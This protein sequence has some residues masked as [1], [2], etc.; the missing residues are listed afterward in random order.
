[1]VHHCK[2]IIIG[3]QEVIL[4]ISRT[5]VLWK[6]MITSKIPQ[7]IASH[8][9][10]LSQFYCG[11]K[12]LSKDWHSSQVLMK[13]RECPRMDIYSIVEVLMMLQ[14]KCNLW[15]TKPEM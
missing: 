2:R 4:Y 6:I 11:I 10:Y 3:A 15:H 8:Y 7:S 14:K 9:N 5:L 13:T 12:C 1:M